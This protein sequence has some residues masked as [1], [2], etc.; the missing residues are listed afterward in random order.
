MKISLIAALD[1]NHA[2]GRAGAMPWHLPEDLKRFKA[3]TLG[4]PVLM[5][6]KTAQAIG[7]PLPGRPNLVLT[8][9]DRAPFA[10]Q[11]V[12]PSVDAAIERAAG[13][14]LAVIGGGE[15]YALALERATH[16]HLTWVDTAVDDA[17]AFFP[18]FEAGEWFETA[19]EA[20]QADAR[21]AY[22]IS[23]VDYERVR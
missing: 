1:R 13:E 2:I 15:V 5:G 7:R 19:R 16:M 20:R 9:G 10:D 18:R 3:L 21:H 14:E 8:R 4:K 17:D 6:R 23:F 11:V 22:A 12:V